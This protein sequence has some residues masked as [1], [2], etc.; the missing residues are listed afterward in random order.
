MSLIR[1][2]GIAGRALP[3]L[4]VPFILPIGLAAQDRDGSIA[5]AVYDADGGQPLVG[6]SVVLLEA[7]R[8]EVTRQDGSFVFADVHPGEYTVVV[9]LIGY[10]TD[11]RFVRVD[12]GD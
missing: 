6:A 9:D 12:P 8:Q 4:I 5:G 10:A 2:I 11:R 1:I 7:H 3:A